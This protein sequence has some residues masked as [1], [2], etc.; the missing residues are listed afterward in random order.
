MQAPGD[1]WHIVRIVFWSVFAGVTLLAIAI[2][3]VRCTWAIIAPWWLARTR[4][5]VRVRIVRKHTDTQLFGRPDVPDTLRSRTD[6]YLTVAFPDDV[7]LELRAPEGIYES[8]E[9]GDAGLLEHDGRWV[10]AFVPTQDP[11]QS[12]PKA[13]PEP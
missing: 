13:L 7:K 2:V 3:A 12:A 9:E 8:V 4:P 1:P 5:H 6:W 10:T 11:W